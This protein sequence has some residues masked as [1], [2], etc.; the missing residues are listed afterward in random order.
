MLGSSTKA[1]SYLSQSA[2]AQAKIWE[3][4]ARVQLVKN[5]D[6]AG[7]KAGAM[8]QALKIEEAL[9]YANKGDGESLD[10]R[11]ANAELA[12]SVAPSWAV[13]WAIRGDVLWAIHEYHPTRKREAALLD[14][15]E[16]AYKK[17]ISLEGQAKAPLPG[18]KPPA[19]SGGAGAPAGARSPAASPP[20]AA[21]GVAARGVASKGGAAKG[22]SARPTTSAGSAVGGGG[23][24]GGGGGNNGGA[25]ANGKIA[26]VRIGLAKIMAE[27]LGEVVADPMAIKEEDRNALVQ[28]Y[29]EAISI[30][31]R[32]VEPYYKVGELLELK[33]PQRAAEVYAKYPAN[34]EA[35]NL[36]DAF[37][38][39]EVVRL[40]LRGK[41]YLKWTKGGTE[42][43]NVAKGLVVMAKVN[44]LDMISSYVEKLEGANQTEI[45][46][47]VYAA[48]NN[49]ATDDPEM[50]AYY[51]RKG[52][53]TGAAALQQAIEHARLMH[54]LM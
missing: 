27:R 21:R 12:V 9:K 31:A 24:L 3:G 37:I 32:D 18:P 22:G 45:L 53:V 44:G 11:L 25:G 43:L 28:L 33:C 40:S 5:L 2:K 35:P 36:D 48:V 16:E 50:K 13:S 7:D 30:D 1:L 4:R 17:A 38:A 34:F 47:E 20:A 10:R 49:R 14:D 41:D 42:V 26:G 19:P 51:H 46:C 23:S 39:G 6:A 29:E 15:A 54:P 52:W 8:D